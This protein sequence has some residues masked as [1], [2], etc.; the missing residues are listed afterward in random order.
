MIEYLKKHPEKIFVPFLEHVQIVLITLAF[1]I[2][3]AA[4]LTLLAL[5]YRRLQNVLGQFLAILYSIP[6]LAF[7]ALLI[8]ITGL[9]RTTAIIV[10][11]VYNQY[12]LVR[13]FLTGLQ[14]VDPAAVEAAK[15]IGMTW[16]QVVRI[17]Q[18]PL[19]KPAIIAGIRLAVVSTVGIATIAASINAGGLGSLLF[20]GLRTMNI[21]KIMWGSL[22]SAGLAIVLNAGLS[23]V[24]IRYRKRG[25]L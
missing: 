10:L 22:L 2:V 1:S 14:E 9:G 7:F 18:L 11:T 17:V 5:K 25:F 15:G 6:S 8:P 23:K 3:I 21:A 16:M 12:L 24:G 13:N 4:V 19:A 20:D